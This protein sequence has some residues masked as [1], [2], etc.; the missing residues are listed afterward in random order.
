LAQT[1]MATY[2]SGVFK[3]KCVCVCIHDRKVSKIK[4]ETFNLVLKKRKLSLIKKNSTEKLDD[5]IPV[6]KVTSYIF[7]R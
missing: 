2:S 7:S 5:A 6:L 3:S 1:G 4:T